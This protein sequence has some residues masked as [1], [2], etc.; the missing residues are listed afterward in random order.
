MNSPATDSNAP[1]DPP[2][3]APAATPARPLYWSI[4]RELWENRFVYV[5]P[6]AIAAIVLLATLIG[7]IGLPGKI[8]NASTLEPSKRRAAVAAP[9]KMAPAPIMLS[10][11][12]VGLIYCLD[13]LHGERRDRSILFWK[14]L[15]VSDLTVVLSKASIPLLVLPSI[16]LGLSFATLAILLLLSS[17]IL[18]GS[19]M[20]PALLWVEVQFF[21]ET[22]VMIYGMTAHTLWLAPI[23]AWLL[24]VSAWARRTPLVWAAL[25]LLGIPLEKA[26]LNSS[27]L[28]S[29]LKYRVTGAME[30]AFAV[31]SS[32]TGE[33][34]IDFSQLTPGNFLG[35]PGLWTGL[36]F[37]T[38]LL[39]IAVR[40]RRNREPI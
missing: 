13:A 35:A 15:P 4:R 5:A 7:T 29:M 18:L 17:A 34:I 32:R 36:A 27:Y 12:V 38:A 30:R 1:L 6:L 28:A 31:R 24:L 19:S 20:S 39:A 16:A 8:S 37:A 11:I 3:L 33:P 9:Y 25:P 2:L 26:L 21:Q 22:L 14:S 40:L 23:Y 10:T